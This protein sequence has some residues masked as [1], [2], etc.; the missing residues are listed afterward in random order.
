MPFFKF[1][2]LGQVADYTK[3]VQTHWIVSFK[4][5]LMTV[6]LYLA[7]GALVG[8]MSWGRK[9]NN[10][11]LFLLLALGGLWAMGIEYYAVN[12]AHR[13]AYS[14]SMLVLPVLNVGILPLLQ[15]LILPA[16]SVLIAR[17]QLLRI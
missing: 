3:F 13:W 11:R 4:D 8:N 5:A 2:G 6:V 15:M 12:F 7:V 17:G 14:Q 1:E 10:K 16:L 9:F